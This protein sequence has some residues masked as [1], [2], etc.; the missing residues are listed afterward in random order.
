MAGVVIDVT[1][2]KGDVSLA[3]DLDQLLADS[4]MARVAMHHAGA[5]GPCQE[6]KDP[7]NIPVEMCKGN[8]AGRHPGS[9]RAEDV[10]NLCQCWVEIQKVSDG[11][12]VADA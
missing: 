7:D 4:G 5:C 10:G 6:N 8:I 1:V 12:A 3:D 11:E 9:T 2:S